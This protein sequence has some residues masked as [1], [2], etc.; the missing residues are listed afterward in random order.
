MDPVWY[1]ADRSLELICRCGRVVRFHI[2]VLAV[3]PRYRNL[4]LYQ[5]ASRL[6]C[7]TCGAK[8]P[9]ISPL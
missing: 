6:R 3:D 9:A 1:R 5:I 2:G 8:G 4:H 7:S